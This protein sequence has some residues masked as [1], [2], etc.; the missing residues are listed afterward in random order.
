MM[1]SGFV[2]D[3]MLEKH[4]TGLDH[5]EQSL[6]SSFIFKKF[7]ESNLLKDAQKIPLRNCNMN[8]L[9]LVH[10]I[11]YLQSSRNEIEN[12]YQHLST[13]DTS[14]C[15]QSWEVASFATGGVLN[16]VEKV[17]AERGGHARDRPAALN[18]KK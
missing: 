3:L 7:K 16:A 14:V 10:K 1:K 4:K 11:D 5:P 8:E 12:G 13:G 15:K 6:R 2:Y 18:E 9:S 17:V